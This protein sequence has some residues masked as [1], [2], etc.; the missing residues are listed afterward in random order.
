MDKLLPRINGPEDLKGLDNQQLE[1]LAEEIRTTLIHTVAKTGGHL[2]PNLGVVELTIALHQVFSSPDDKFVFDVGHQSYVHKLL[3]GRQS[4]FFSLRQYKGLSGFPKFQESTH[5]A[6]NTGHSSTSISAAIGLALGRDQQTAQYDVISV[7]GDGALTGGMAFEA[8]NHAGHL[9][10][11]LIVVL[12]DNEMSIASNVGAMSSYLSRMRSDPMYYRG[13]EEIEHL[14]KKL[15]A[16]GSRVLRIM[17]RLK[18][19][20]KYL[21]VPGMLFEELGFT[22]LGPVDGHN[23]NSLKSVFRSAKNTKGPVLVHALTRKGRGYLPA[24][25]NPDLF[26]GIGA[27]DIA[28]GEPKKKPGPP[29]YTKVFSDALIEIARNDQKVV[30]VTAAM[31]GGTGIDRFSEEFPKRAF[32][33]GIAEQHAVTMSAGLAAAG[34]KPVVAIYSTFLQR[35]YDQVM[36]DV[37]LQNLPVVFALDRAGIVGEDGETHQG[38]FDFSYLRNIPRMTIMAPKDENELRHML[39]TAIK[40]DGPVS[41]RYPRG[42]GVGAALEAPMHELPLGKGEILRQ[43]E[44]VSIIAIGNTVYPSLEA[45][46]LLEKEGI[47]AAVVNARYV[48]P[49]DNELILNQAEKSGKILTVEEHVRAGGFGSAVL[50]LLAQQDLR[51]EVYNLAVPD[52]FIQQG[53]TVIMRKEY[54][55]DGPGIADTVRKRFFS[56]EKGLKNG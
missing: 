31:P 25:K 21:V 41:I 30:A 35:A 54:K 45:A 7:I 42:K 5:D 10:A 22:Y 4:E 16:V 19:T 29:S 13:K 12:N 24:E 39:L 17:D 43:G 32:D 6:F 15:P 46:E 28:T 55:L 48:K 49:L 34:Y 8:L 20:V 27:F 14:L 2:A 9:G 50:E 51:V 44:D 38:L 36:H 3:T 52:E 53:D 47:A 40:Q 11:N 37:A 1:Q 33:V 26:H 56:S 23:F 18:D